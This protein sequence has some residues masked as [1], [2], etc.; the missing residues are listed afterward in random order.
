[1]LGFRFHKPM[2][3]SYGNVPRM[4]P[5]LSPGL[6]PFQ[7]LSLSPTSSRRIILTPCCCHGRGRRLLHIFLP[8]VDLQHLALLPHLRRRMCSFFTSSCR[9]P[10]YPSIFLH[11]SVCRTTYTA[12]LD[13]RPQLASSCWDHFIP[14]RRNTWLLPHLLLLLVA[15]PILYVPLY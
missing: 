3:S 6:S 1:M 15:R 5:L 10:P 8:E 14:L 7:G 11:D 9:Q 4:T 2:H 13:C 12:S